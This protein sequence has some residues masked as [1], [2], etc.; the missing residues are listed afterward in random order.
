MLFRSNEFIKSENKNFTPEYEG[1]KANYGVNKITNQFDDTD[2]KKAN[3]FSSNEANQKYLS[4]NNWVG[5]YGKRIKLTANSQLKIAQANPVV[6]KDKVAYPTYGEIGFVE[7][8][9]SFD[10]VKL[11]YFRG[12]DYNDPLWN[13]L[14]DRMS[15]EETCALLQDGLRYTNAVESISAPS[16]SQQNGAIAPN[17]NRNYK[18]LPNQS[19]FRGFAEEKD[20]ENVGQDP[21]IF[22]CNGLVGA[23]YN[24]DLIQR[25]GEQTGEEAIWA[26][27]NGIYG[28]GV[29]I[30]IG[31]ASCRG[32]V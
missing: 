5:T 29:N 18:D 17:H 2:F 32:R 31:R 13:T 22:A 4:R 21:E 15:Y 23:T 27:Y 24:V 20:K 11:I 1:Q 8:G 9:D 25:I 3:I 6:E 7:T 28:L 26:V 14:L 10:E 16:T 19:A 12:K 30:Q